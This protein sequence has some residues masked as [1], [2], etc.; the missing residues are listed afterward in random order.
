MAAASAAETAAVIRYTY[1]NAA[2]NP[3]K[4]VLTLNGDGS[5][6]YVTELGAPA[7]DSEPLRAV[8][9]DRAIQLPAALRADLFSAARKS[10]YFSIPCEGGGRH[11]A[12]QGKKTLEYRGPD[13]QG[14]CTFNWSNDKQIEKINAAFQAIALTLDAGSRLEMEYRYSP[15][16][17]PAE[18]EALEEQVRNGQAI[19]IVN[20]EPIL[21]KVAQDDAVLQAARRRAQDLLSMAHADG[22]EGH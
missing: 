9:Q 10:N 11:I 17:L 12:F 16:R 22:E 6:R 7:P 18:L 8:K 20:I 14:A 3:A 13:G 4:Y 19:A 5:G 15:L 1:E 2:L 21:T